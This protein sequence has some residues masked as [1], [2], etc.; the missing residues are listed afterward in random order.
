MRDP[1]VTQKVI[2][3]REK[4]V[5]DVKEKANKE[6]QEKSK[7]KGKFKVNSIKTSL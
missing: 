4:H 5:K 2:K 3:E 1:V 7:E 6:H